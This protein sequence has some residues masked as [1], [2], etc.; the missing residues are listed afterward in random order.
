MALLNFSMAYKFL[1]TLL[2]KA[3]CVYLEQ[4]PIAQHHFSAWISKFGSNIK[5]CSFFCVIYYFNLKTHF[6]VTMGKGS[7]K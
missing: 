4:I 5:V 2:I 7:R 1:L 6:V 3:P